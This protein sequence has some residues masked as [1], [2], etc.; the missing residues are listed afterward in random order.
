[1]GKIIA[2]VDLTPFVGPD[3]PVD[4]RFDSFNTD[5]DAG[6]MHILGHVD[7]TTAQEIV[8]LWTRLGDQVVLPDR[9]RTAF[10]RR[11]F[12]I[13]QHNDDCDM[14]PDDVEDA[15]ILDV[16]GAALCCGHDGADYIEFNTAV[17]GYVRYVD[18][19]TPL[20]RPV[21][22][23]SICDRELYDQVVAQ[24]TDGDADVLV[25]TN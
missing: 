20:A 22:I 4:Q 10:E 25:L 7:A 19:G 21:T 3:V 16:Y 9:N 18:E 11:W 24:Y 2:P 6:T 23:V 5:P 17:S 14:D 8:T 12:V 13:D 1:M 15:E